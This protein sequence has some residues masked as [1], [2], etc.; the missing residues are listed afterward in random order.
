MS[1]GPDLFDRRPFSNEHA[2]ALHRVE[3]ARNDPDLSI[4]R[5]RQ[6]VFQITTGLLQAH[7]LRKLAMK[8]K[9]DER[10]RTDA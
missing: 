3:V 7:N 10:N 8:E 6:R 1:A 2:E 5:A 9:H 4:T